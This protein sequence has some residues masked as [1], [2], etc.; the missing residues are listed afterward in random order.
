MVTHF[1]VIDVSIMT[2]QST[3]RGALGVS[4]VLALLA[5]TTAGYL[6]WASWNMS[7]IAGCGEQS[8]FD[9]SELL[10]GK[11][12]KWLGVPVSLLGAAIYGLLF[13][14][15]TVM[16]L[17][18]QLRNALWSWLALTLLALLAAGAAAWFLVV[19]AFVLKEFCPYCCLIHACGLVIGLLVL[20]KLPRGGREQKQAQMG[21]MLGFWAAEDDLSVGDMTV[22]IESGQL[23]VVTLVA[24][25]GLATL[26][27]VQ[28]FSVDESFLVEVSTVD[29]PIAATQRE[30]AGATSPQPASQSSLP[31]SLTV[32]DEPSAEFTTDFIPDES[33]KSTTNAG[34]K[35][36]GTLKS[37]NLVPRGPVM[38]NGLLVDVSKLPV[39]GDPR[40][41]HVMVELLDYTCQHCRKFHPMMES[42]VHRYSGQVAIVVR[43]CALSPKCNLNVTK[44]TRVHDKAC[45]YA[46]LS[47]AVWRMNP[48]KFPEFHNW[49]MGSDQIPSLSAA[50]QRAVQLVGPEVIWREVKSDA[51]RSMLEE[52]NQLF[53][54]AKRG[55]PIL[56]A[57][58][59]ATSGV[60]KS[61]EQMYRALESHLGVHPIEQSSE[62]LI[63]Q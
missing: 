27:G 4:S 2:S 56:L 24:V 49:L 63:G 11:W 43:L 17:W 29:T 37:T 28:W 16:L 36:G 7:P 60:P 9:C 61:V 1:H 33:T 13:S 35:V 6:A 54:E 58:F 8:L 34:S 25:C 5:A 42:V 38:I 41:E 44:K 31:E 59:G 19:Q 52:N 18:E 50:N 51:V 23:A 48:Q 46:K 3:L 39:L 55:L 26:I 22:L 47:L 57:T 10:S 32:V 12:S 45:E 40:A 15:A 30:D 20:W 21:Q 14:L 53:H 62:T